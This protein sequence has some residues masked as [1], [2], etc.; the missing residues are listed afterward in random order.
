MLGAQ[1]AMPTSAA[2]PTSVCDGFSRAPRLLFVLAGQSNMAG[3]DRSPAPSSAT[4]SDH[5]LAFTQRSDRWELAAHPLH[6]DKP[7]KVGVGPGLAFAQQLLSHCGDAA[8]GGIGLVPC[9]FGGS[10]LARWEEGGDL[11]DEC[12]RRVALCLETPP[13]DTRP[14]VLAGLLWHQGENDCGDAASAATYASRLPATLDALRRAIGAPNLPVVVGELGYWLDQA[15]A[16][17]A[18]ASAINSAIVA[19]PSA[20]EHSMCVS[21]HGL[22]H[23]GDRLHFDA[24]AAKTLGGRYADAWLHLRNAL[25]HKEPSSWRR[26]DVTKAKED[27][28]GDD[29]SREEDDEG[30]PTK[31]RRSAGETQGKRPRPFSF[32]A[33]SRAADE[34]QGRETTEAAV[35]D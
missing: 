19:A 34:C 20:V 30:I 4:A 27:V 29:A 22:A 12:V 21:A 10:E 32:P 7:E 11:F 18:H 16:D 25:E 23:K 24:R 35:R 15:D 9:S 6:A 5:I 31:R 13:T 3:R 2:S 1:M 33:T 28:E 26:A 14:L 17:Y 8:I